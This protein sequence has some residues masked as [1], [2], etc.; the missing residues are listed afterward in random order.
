MVLKD[1]L[2]KEKFQYLELLNKNSDIQRTLSNVEST[3]TPD[4]AK[5]IPQNTL[6]LMTGM[7][8]KEQPEKL[9][10]FLEDLNDRACAGVAIKLGRFIDELDQSVMDIA[11]QLG[12]PILKIPMDQTL[13]N[14]YHEVLSYIWDTQ[15][16]YLLRALNAQQKISN[17]ILQG[18][19]LKSIIHNIAVI[20]DRPVMIIDIF[21]RILEYGYTFTKTA[22]QNAQKIIHEIQGKK[23]LNR[24]TYGVYQKNGCKLCIYPMRGVERTTKYL[25]A[26]DFDPKDK[27]ENILIMK[28]ILMSLEMYFY[29]D[30]YVK[31]NEMKRKEEFLS[32]FLEQLETNSWNERQVLA[33]GECYGLKQMSQYKMVIIQIEKED[34]RKFNHVN[35]SKREERYILIYDWMNYLLNKE[36]DILIFPQES[37]WRYICLIQGD[38]VN[39]MK[40]FTNLHDMIKEKFH[41]DIVVAQGE[42]ILSVINLNHS[43]KEAEQCLI[44]GKQDEEYPYLYRFRPKTMKDLLKYLPENEMKDL[45]I[46]IL[47]GLAYPKNQMEEELRKTLSTFLFCNNSITR[48]ADSLFV[49]RNTIKYRL[50]KCRELLGVDFS[51]A[52]TCFQLQLA[53]QFTENER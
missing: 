12:I 48:T 36:E 15:N 2:E 20:L 23:K 26:L 29:R 1:I 46:Q 9:C 24:E 44:D 50:K 16:D 53:L 30:L 49:H 38:Q 11:N 52:S 13:G 33:I 3:E 27:E 19:S 10:K 22:R 39:D 37:K 18:S 34:K 5:Y 45:C 21:G 41:L 7:A 42:K 6:L 31:Y 28:Q 25:A 4:V 51:D 47:K 40:Y 8:F 32:V 35:F 14:V 17:L 43:L